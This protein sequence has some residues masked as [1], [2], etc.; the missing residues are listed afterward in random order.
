MADD[1]GQ[2]A[3]AGQAD[4]LPP[5]PQ[6]QQATPREDEQEE[7]H[8]QEAP[9]DQALAATVDDEFPASLDLSR[10]G[11]MLPE[12][13]PPD[14]D[15]GG[16][17]GGGGDGERAPSAA[18]P[19]PPSAAAD[20]TAAAAPMPAAEDG[21]GPQYL[22]DEDA[23]L[24]RL[25][26]TAPG[27]YD[28]EEYPASAAA[29]AAA[30]E[31]TTAGAPSS[32]PAG[33]AMDSMMEFT[34]R[35]TQLLALV[36]EPSQA[37]DR[38]GARGGDGDDDDEA[39]GF[40]FGAPPPPPS[41]PA[42]SGATTVQQQQQQQQ[43]RE[44]PQQAAAPST[45][46]EQQ[47]Q[48]RAP[49][50]PPPP[51]RPAPSAPTVEAA[52]A[53]AAR[54]P[55]PQ[56]A[57]M[58]DWDLDEEL[59]HMLATEGTEIPMAT[60]ATAGRPATAAAAAAAGHRTPGASPRGRLPLM[61]EEAEALERLQRSELRLA[62]RRAAAEQ[63][64]AARSPG[65]GGGG[66]GGG[67][68]FGYDAADAARA[69]PAAAGARPVSRPRP[70]AI[71]L[72]AELDELFEEAA[73]IEQQQHQ[74]VQEQR[75]RDQQPEEDAD[76]AAAEAEAEAAAALPAI[77]PATLRSLDAPACGVDAA[78]ARDRLRARAADP[79]RRP[80]RLAAEVPTAGGGEVLPVTCADGTRVYCRLAPADKAELDVSSDLDDD[81]EDDEEMDA[82]AAATAAAAAGTSTAAEVA[83]A[84]KRARRRERRLGRMLLSAPISELMR[85]VEEAEM[86]E[87]VLDAERA[88]GEEAARALLRQEEERQRQ[89]LER[90]RQA[91]DDSAVAAA[92]GRGKA[93]RGVA[94][95]AAAGSGGAPS[96][97]NPDQQLLWVDKHA[98][99]AFPHLLS[100]ERTNREVARWVKA[101]DRRVF[102]GQ[103]GVH[104]GGGAGADDPS[105]EPLAPDGAPEA[106]LLLIAGA[107]GTGKTT[108]AHV[109]ARHCGYRPLEINASDDRSAQ[110]L[111]SRVRD[112]A[113]MSAALD[114]ARRPN[115]I[116]V[117]EV[118]G[119]TGG[120]EGHSA[121]AALLKLVLGSGGGGGGRKGGKGRGGGRGNGNG[122]DDEANGAGSGSDDDENAEAGQA[123]AAASKKRGG[124]R[125][126]RGHP[127]LGRPVVCLCNDL[128]APALRPLRDKARVVLFRPP[129]QERLVERLAAV[130]RAEGFAV[131]RAALHLLAERTQCDIRACLNVLQ[132][133]SS[134]RRQRGGGAGGA[135]GKSNSAAPPAPPRALRA[136]EVAA[137]PLGQK[138]I[139]KSAMAVMQ[140]LLLGIGS[141]A[142]AGAAGGGGAGLLPPKGGG[143][144]AS[145]AAAAAAA[146]AQQQQQQ[147]QRS[148]VS[149]LYSA[150]M[151]FGDDDLLA[152]A[153]QENLHDLVQ[154]DVDMRGCAAACDALSEAETFGSRAR[155]GSSGAD[156]GS[157]LL[158]VP[159]CLIAASG[160][161]GARRARSGAGFAAAAPSGFG[162]GLQWP[163]AG[164]EASRRAAAARGV[165]RSWAARASP[166]T[167]RGALTA[168]VGAA[169]SGGFGTGAGA[170][171]A[172][173]D[174]L[175][176]VR[177]MLRPAA[178][179]PV[180]PSLWTAAEGALA[181]QLSLAMVSAGVSYALGG[182]AL[183]DGA[184]L[185]SSAT[186]AATLGGG[187]GGG[188][189]GHHG[190]RYGQQQHGGGGAGGGAAAAA[191]ALALLARPAPLCPPL[192][193]MHRYDG[194][195][196]PYGRAEVPMAVRQALAR[197]AQDE[198]MRRAEANRFGGAPAVAGEP[199]QQ[200][201]FDAPAAA[202]RVAAAVRGATG[203][204]GGVMPPRAA[205]K[206]PADGG[207][208][209]ANGAARPAAP[210]RLN[211]LDQL[212]RQKVQQ[213]Q[214]QHLGP[215][216]AWA[217]GGGG[218]GG[219]GAGGGAAAG[220][221]AGPK[222]ANAAAHVALYAYNE[223]YTNAVKRP[224]RVREL[225]L[226]AADV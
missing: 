217:A 132:L 16:A 200:G 203:T 47:Q 59:E 178:L 80:R 116:V 224:L 34:L 93:P 144:G 91:A 85:R 155:K 119:A 44:P 95:A 58:D 188:G 98:P 134:R 194:L 10:P 152:A 137:L 3:S 75:A 96:S 176:A 175:N 38:P 148:E 123:R 139:A 52:P 13:V 53:P 226:G 145:A 184:G 68:A 46:A 142:G 198:T 150:V 223:G 43:A 76:A 7:Q 2:A 212:K 124:G 169:A 211:W 83:A 8:Q 141:G 74:Q 30:P 206:R 22:D 125:G 55:P 138:D 21:S 4:P 23:E 72:D 162:G 102:G 42:A 210:R 208:E 220:G 130:C 79:A 20:A 97:A 92:S 117:D 66:G 140:D 209:D 213:Q 48:Q 146:K 104:G 81:E 45:T 185:L 207:A 164:A 222:A 94:S 54:A 136:S 225:L 9:G 71:D 33:Q 51:R 11:L 158:Y 1:G 17:G 165:L 118:D 201:G 56:D 190:A 156:A 37:L 111:T 36:D 197:A 24:L 88:A 120:A 126:G 149:R 107:P 151:D 214:Q 86:R 179:R 154:L 115:L 221:A 189:F 14:A 173:H 166:E 105:A 35:E 160:A 15:G 12:S 218:A 82:A 6:Q 215:A 63:A 205:G 181:R 177:A 41:F 192:D 39:G 157:L 90:Q 49:M 18:A 100:D 61:E 31:P 216:A 199:G 101:W 29:A 196:D 129:P 108:L 26:E 153:L 57:Q 110:A 182:Q 25:A 62:A 77:K 78:A 60:A 219:G 121:V 163:R 167:V 122:G 113:E 67:G 143:G 168:G 135:G 87:A 99:K 103:R 109:V 204:G 40:E 170:G 65:G 172:C 131:E 174:L 64:A 89:R 127:P 5:P 114:A 27:G 193:L 186:V 19:A 147:R 28:D 70:V 183:A 191:D 73:G 50:A 128:H 112:A 195:A 161:T 180:A 106:R 187:G 133:L 159:A 69:P 84:A 202:A 32:R 171:A